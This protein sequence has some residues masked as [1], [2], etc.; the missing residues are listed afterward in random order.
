MQIYG[1]SNTMSHMLPQGAEGGVNKTL[2]THSPERL[3]H[4]FLHKR[5]K[6]CM[7]KYHHSF[8]SLKAAECKD[9]IHS[10]VKSVRIFL[11]ISNG[12]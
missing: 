3:T 1:P 11:L 4:A 10:S 2:E 5:K 8:G 12:G 7:L 6:F 9:R